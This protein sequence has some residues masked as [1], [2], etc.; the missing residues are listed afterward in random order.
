VKGCRAE[1]ESE[2]PTVL[3]MS[4]TR[5]AAEGKGPALVAPTEG[6]KREGMVQPTMTMDRVGASPAGALSEGVVAKADVVAG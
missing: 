1:R 5:T 3:M 4:R 6:G 2:G